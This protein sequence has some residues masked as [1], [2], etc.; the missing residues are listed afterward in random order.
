MKYP[1]SN[2]IEE[3][4]QYFYIPEDDLLDIFLSNESNVDS[5]QT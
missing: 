4:D 1:Q 5:N 2:V 3:I